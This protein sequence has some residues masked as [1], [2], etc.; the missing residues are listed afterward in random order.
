MTSVE[1]LRRGQVHG[2]GSK[3]ELGDGYAHRLK[4]TRMNGGLLLR[5]TGNPVAGGGEQG[6][7]IMYAQ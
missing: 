4:T 6:N 7:Q 5:E 1:V 3:N 2:E